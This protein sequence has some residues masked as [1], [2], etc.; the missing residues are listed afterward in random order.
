VHKVADIKWPKLVPVKTKA[1]DSNGVLVQIKG[2]KWMSGEEVLKPSTTGFSSSTF[3]FSIPGYSHHLK[4]KAI[5]KSY[6]ASCTFWAVMI[7]SV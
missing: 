2:G 7:T 6:W 3:K 5:G 1:S 4:W